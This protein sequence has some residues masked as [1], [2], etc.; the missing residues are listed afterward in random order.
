M[1]LTG[2]LLKL[3][4]R[5]G[6]M[7]RDDGSQFNWANTIAHVLDGIDVRRVKVK[8]EDV[9]DFENAHKVGDLFDGEVSVEV[10][11]GREGPYLAIT[12]LPSSSPQDFAKVNGKKSAE[13]AF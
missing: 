11:S 6:T 7:R 1:R 13:P 5:S 3:E 4:P 10:N 8:G 9:L 12:Y 2:Q